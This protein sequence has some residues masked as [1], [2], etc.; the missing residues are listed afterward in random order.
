MEILNES[1][2]MIICYSIMTMTTF[3]LEDEQVFRNGYFFLACF[4]VIVIVNCIY[5][6]LIY[7]QKR[8]LRKRIEEKKKRIKAWFNKMKTVR[9]NLKIKLS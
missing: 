4:G 7:K 6:I 3:I 8:D 1:L 5:L 9:E 2:I